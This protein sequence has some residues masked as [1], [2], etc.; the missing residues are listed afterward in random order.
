[1]T[2]VQLLR[3]AQVLYPRLLDA[4]F[5]QAPKAKGATA[6]QMSLASNDQL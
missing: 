5:K 4:T 2:I 1:V 6:E 3:G